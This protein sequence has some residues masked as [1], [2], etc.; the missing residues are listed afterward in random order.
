MMFAVI[1]PALISGATIDLC[2]AGIGENGHLAFN[3]P[4][5]AVSG[6][7]TT[8]EDTAVAI[9]LTCTDVD[10]DPVTFS[11][12]ALTNVENLTLEG[13]ANIDATGNSGANT[14]TGN[15]GADK[16][17]G[18]GGNDTLVAKDGD[19][20]VHGS[21]QMSW[22]D[23]PPLL[24]Y[25]EGVAVE[26]AVRE[27]RR[28]QAAEALVHLRDEPP[29]VARQR[30]RG[31]VALPRADAEPERPLAR[32]EHE[33]LRPVV[34]DDDRRMPHPRLLAP[35]QQIARARQRDAGHRVEENTTRPSGSRCRETTTSRAPA[36]CTRR[37]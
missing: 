20:L 13:S 1:T 25:L 17:Y 3:D 2:L 11:I 33:R 9:P 5:V 37:M 15:L 27:R 12:A 28:V 18:E 32:M 36:P 7:V 34:F 35:Q 14:L 6:A 8:S 4:P 16:L 31:G 21:T 26:L 24:N 29:Q 30:E 22:H 23:G 10:G 19:N